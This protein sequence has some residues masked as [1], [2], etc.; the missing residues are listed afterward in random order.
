MHSSAGNPIVDGLFSS[1]GCPHRYSFPGCE[2]TWKLCK[3]IHENEIFL[4]GLGKDGNWLDHSSCQ[5]SGERVLTQ[6]PKV[7]YSQKFIIR[8]T[9]DSYEEIIPDFLDLYKFLTI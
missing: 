7:K 6:V 1:T 9:T 5:N 8:G 4:K 2:W 3:G